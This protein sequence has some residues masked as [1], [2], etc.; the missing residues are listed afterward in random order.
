MNEVPPV[1]V[2]QVGEKQ[3][4]H[5]SENNSQMRSVGSTDR[6]EPL[7]TGSDDPP[8][9]RAEAA[10]V[11]PE[12]EPE[13]RGD[14][15]AGG[16]CGEQRHIGVLLLLRLAH[17][18]VSLG[19]RRPRRR[20]AA[21]RQAA[22][23]AARARLPPARA[24][25]HRDDLEEA[26]ERQPVDRARRLLLLQDCFDHLLLFRGRPVAQPPG[27]RELLHCRRGGGLH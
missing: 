20:L 21:Q 5:D 19:L 25:L 6:D 1:E 17:P 18:Q 14:R 27:L 4:T 22:V 3:L 15:G 12:G 9:G 26:E 2:N 13:H 24:A 7:R 16:F 11:Q 8:G 23:A 10:R